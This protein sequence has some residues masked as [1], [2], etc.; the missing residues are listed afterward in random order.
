[1]E[2]GTFFAN[3]V[4][5]ENEAKWLYG[6]TGTKKQ[7]DVWMVPE[8]FKNLSFVQHLAWQRSVSSGESFCFFISF[9]AVLIPLYSAKKTAPNVPE[10]I[11]SLEVLF[12]SNGQISQKAG[13]RFFSSSGILV[14]AR[15]VDLSTL[16]NLLKTHGWSSSL[17]EISGLF[18][19][20]D[21][22]IICWPLLCSRPSCTPLWHPSFSLSLA[23]SAFEE[24]WPLLL[25]PCLCGNSWQALSS[26]KS[27][28]TLVVS[29]FLLGKLCW[30]SSTLSSAF[31]PRARVFR[32]S[33]CFSLTLSPSA[34][35]SMHISAFASLPCNVG[36]RNTYPLS[37]TLAVYLVQT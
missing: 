11:G 2:C 7:R 12:S 29:S 21:I 9:T 34:S 4:E 19:F 22:F 32:L 28:C 8:T 27:T 23:L 24:F 30:T 13:S 20:S 6:C 10:P 37:A 14:V 3:A 16:D 1:M 31:L 33:S 18:L 15:C 36:E 17:V 26:A 25:T 35:V 5:L